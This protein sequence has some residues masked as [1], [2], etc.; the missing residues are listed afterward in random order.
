MA[1]GHA[2]FPEKPLAWEVPGASS[3]L[4]L[5]GRARLFGQDGKVSTG[6]EKAAFSV[7]WRSQEQGLARRERENMQ[8]QQWAGRGCVENQT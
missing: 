8:P 6:R 7:E 3:V 4:F 1:S 2:S 5:S